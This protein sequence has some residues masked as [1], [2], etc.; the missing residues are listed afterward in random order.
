M[1][2]LTMS[3]RIRKLIIAALL[4]AASVSMTG[5]KEPATKPALPGN[6]APAFSLP[7]MNGGTVRLA[8]HAGTVVV[9]DF[10]ATW[11]GPCKEATV[12]LESVQKKYGKQRVAIIGISVD[13]GPG[14][15]AMVKNYAS[16]Q[17]MTYQILIDDGTAKRAY[18]V[19]T[20][21]STFVLDKN[22]IIRDRYPGYRPGIGTE[23]GRDIEKLL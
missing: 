6:P 22:H 21:P 3:I 4:I 20:V 13:E 8:D 19:T 18:G 5:C 11:C 2:T 15:A 16:R 1:L 9:L 23:I 12:E 7:D 10:W 17:G 14:A